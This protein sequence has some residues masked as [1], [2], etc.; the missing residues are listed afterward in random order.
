MLAT[1]DSTTTIG[2]I[3]AEGDLIEHQFR[4]A[5]F[6]DHK[7][8]GE[9]NAS[10]AEKQNA[11]LSLSQSNGKTIAPIG[12]SS[13]MCPDCIKFFQGEAQVHQQSVYTVDADGVHIFRPDGSTR[14]NSF[15]QLP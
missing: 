9:F 13:P 6:L 5:G 1:Y 10:H 3:R 14:G 11:V 2:A 4:P 15:S 8:T 12:I 7:K